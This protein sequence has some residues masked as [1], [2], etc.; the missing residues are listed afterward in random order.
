MGYWIYRTGRLPVRTGQD[1]QSV[2]APVTAAGTGHSSRWRGSAASLG[3]DLSDEPVEA[4]LRQQDSHGQREHGPVRAWL[5]TQPAAAPMPTSSSTA[6]DVTGNR[7]STRPR[8]VED[9]EGVTV[10]V[11]VTAPP[12]AVVGVAVVFAGFSG[13]GAVRADGG[14]VGGAAISPISRVG[15]TRD[16]NRRSARQGRDHQRQNRHQHTDEANPGQPDQP[17]TADLTGRRRLGWSRCGRCS[18]ASGV[19]FPSLSVLIGTRSHV[20][21]RPAK[22]VTVACRRRPGWRRAGGMV[23]LTS[24]GRCV[25]RRWPGRERPHSTREPCPRRR[26]PQSAPNT[27]ILQFL[28]GRFRHQRRWPGRPGTNLPTTRTVP[29]RSQRGHRYRRS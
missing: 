13:V 16:P 6:W 3:T 10:T 19:M 27:G 24:P 17:M 23:G 21:A 4:Q 12:A 15:Q 14:G 11:G 5:P 29:A 8:L 7:W 2:R 26:P 1:A 22:Q 9:A 20:R 18:C 25:S 28:D